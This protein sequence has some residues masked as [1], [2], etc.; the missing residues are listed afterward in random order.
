MDPKIRITIIGGG[1]AGYTAAIRA[2]RLGGEITI[3]EGNNIGGTCLNWG[4]IPVKSLLQA[5]SILNDIKKS[6]TFGIKCHVDEI[7]YGNIV[8]RKNTVVD[9][10]TKGVQSLL[11][12]KNIK[13][14]NDSASLVDSKTVLLKGTNEKLRSDFILIA[15]GSK[16]SKIPIPG[17]DNPNV[18]NSNQFLA[19]RE[20][21]SEIIIIGGGV[22]GIELGQFLN[23]MGTKVSIIEMM[24][25]IIPGLDLE[26][27]G[28]MK[29]RLTRAGIKIINNA[30]IFNI[31]Q[32]NEKTSV[33]YSIDGKSRSVSA[34]KVLVSVGRKPN[35][36]NLNIHS[37]G[38]ETKDNFICVNEHMQTNI[39]GVYAAGDVI[40]GCML[41]HVAMAESECAIKNIFGQKSSMEY[42][43]V[44][45]CIYTSP[46]VASVGLTEE[47]ARDLYDIQIGKFPLRAN[48]KALIMDETDGLVKIVSD[49]KYGEILGVH[50]IGPHATDMIAEAVLAINLEATVDELAN[51]IH[52]HPTLSEAIMEAA[53]VSCGGAIHIP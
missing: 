25:Y 38:L 34:E 40:G 20:L 9:K 29:E 1:V 37:I 22:I 23:A 8:D 43:A 47:Q 18:M 15:T 42:K 50:I 52:P 30:K 3:V 36:S 51:S 33:S 21:P 31:E 48:G 28:I 32:V 16:P 6:E 26:I 35:I 53:L 17:Y 24:P 4:C 45:S 41:A 49:K 19:K 10:L 46:E 14:I 2:A 13:V 5:S 39:E 7:N 27:S 44:P 11:R 12:S